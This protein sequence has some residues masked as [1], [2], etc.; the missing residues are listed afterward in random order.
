MK[1]NV[2]AEADKVINSD[3][4]S[5]YGSVEDSFARIAT[6]FNATHPHGPTIGPDHVASLLVCMK[7]VRDGYSPENPD[8]VLDAIGYLGLLDQVRQSAKS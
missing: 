6:A 2:I 5:K 7:L 1:R 8:H 4:P 3:R